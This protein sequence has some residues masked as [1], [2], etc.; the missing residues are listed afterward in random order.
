MDCKKKRTFY[1]IQTIPNIETNQV[2]QLRS[3][4]L[5]HTHWTSWSYEAEKI[6]CNSIKGF[7]EKIAFKTQVW[8]V[9][10]WIQKNTLKKLW[11]EVSTLNGSNEGTWQMEIPSEAVQTWASWP[12]E[13]SW[14]SCASRSLANGWQIPA[15][16]T[17][18]SWS[19]IFWTR[20]KI[21]LFN[22]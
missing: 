7:N 21:F 17:R 8:E 15:E 16:K 19:D 9:I 10:S 12:T 2:G 6:A 4:F 13:S 22:G 1:S 20:K 18:N 3:S 5:L 14:A 11:L